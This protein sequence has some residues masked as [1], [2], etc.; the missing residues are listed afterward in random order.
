M[1][2][3]LPLTAH[4]DI[5]SL[6]RIALLIQRQQPIR[7]THQEALVA[8]GQIQQRLYRVV[9][10]RTGIQYRLELAIN[11]KIQQIPIIRT[12]HQPILQHTKWCKI[13]ILLIDLP[14]GKWW[15]LELNFICGYFEEFQVTL[16]HYYDSVLLAVEKDL[17]ESLN[18]Q[19]ALLLVA[20][21]WLVQSVDKEFALL[22]VPLDELVLGAVGQGDEEFGVGD[23]VA[24]E[25]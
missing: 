20:L 3:E 12:N 16:T 7:P 9:L 19:V 11:G 6:F 23:L 24:V 18:V 8:I 17:V 13:K 5:L 25:G 1:Q 4:V 21:L 14:P 15:V 2:V 10:T 22:E